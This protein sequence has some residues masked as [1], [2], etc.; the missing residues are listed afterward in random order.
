LL[1][2]TLLSTCDITLFLWQY[3]SVCLTHDNSVFVVQTKKLQLK[4]TASVLSKSR[5]SWIHL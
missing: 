3:T 4:Q 2:Y 1:I 5:Y